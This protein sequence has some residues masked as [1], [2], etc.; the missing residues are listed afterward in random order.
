M[1][2]FCTAPCQCQELRLHVE[3]DLHAVNMHHHSCERLAAYLL[4]TGLLTDNDTAVQNLDVTMQTVTM[5]DKH[6]LEGGESC[7]C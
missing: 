4:L 5:S 6:Q 1:S 7:C 3:A 2:H